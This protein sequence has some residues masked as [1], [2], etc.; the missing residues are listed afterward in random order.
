VMK[1]QV[2]GLAGYRNDCVRV[3]GENLHSPGYGVGA[4]ERLCLR[5]QACGGGLHPWCLAC[6]MSNASGGNPHLRGGNSG[7]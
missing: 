3:C 5:R 4:A 1:I 6:A 2:P 7:C